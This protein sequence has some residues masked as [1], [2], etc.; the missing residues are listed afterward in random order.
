[1]LELGAHA[2][3][4]HDAIG[5]LA[6]EAGV[7]LLIAVGDRREQLAEGARR[8]HVEVVEAPDA[9]VAVRLVAEH[10][11]PGDA[12]LVKASRAV[13]LEQV[14]EALGARGAVR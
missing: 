5:A 13:G 4:A 14:A 9:T 1:M 11:R 12:V 7:D 10:V 2:D 3:D 6:G 8:A